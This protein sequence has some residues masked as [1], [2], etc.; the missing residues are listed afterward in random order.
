MRQIN[1]WYDE[2]HDLVVLFLPLPKDTDGAITIN[3]DGT[4]TAVIADGLCP[5]KKLKA[6]R[7]A[8]NHIE[9]GDL[10][11][12]KIVQDIEKRCHDAES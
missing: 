9:N 10:D 6:Y 2:Q 1:K 4:Y 7:H 11:D 3:E 8:L 12:G 5:E